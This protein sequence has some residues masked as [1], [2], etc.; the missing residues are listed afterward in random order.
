MHTQWNTYSTIK[1]DGI[2]PFEAMNEA[3][4]DYAK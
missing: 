3:W 1:N 4:C 2:M